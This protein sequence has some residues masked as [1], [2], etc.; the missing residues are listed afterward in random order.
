M[1]FQYFQGQQP[2]KKKDKD[3]KDFEKN[4]FFQNLSANTLLLSRTKFLLAQ[5][6]KKIKIVVFA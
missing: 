3:A 1:I 5:P 2:T 6:A 4:K